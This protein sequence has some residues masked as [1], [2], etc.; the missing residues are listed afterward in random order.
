VSH[1]IVN[2]AT[3]GDLESTF[4]NKGKLSFKTLTTLEEGRKTQ[5]MHFSFRPVYSILTLST[6]CLFAYSFVQRDYAQKFHWCHC[7][8]FSLQLHQSHYIIPSQSSTKYN[9]LHLQ[10]FTLPQGLHAQDAKAVPDSCYWRIT[11]KTMGHFTH[12]RISSHIRSSNYLSVGEGN[13]GIKERRIFPKR[14][15]GCH[16][17]FKMTNIFFPPFMSRILAMV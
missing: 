16:K 6:V 12:D 2:K 11:L 3:N 17:P 4:S 10:P 9:S 14:S 7:L 1:F 5:W 13:A 8:L 15:F